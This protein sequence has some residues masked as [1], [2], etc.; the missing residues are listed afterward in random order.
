MVA[1]AEAEAIGAGDL[2]SGEVVG[3]FDVLFFLLGDVGSIDDA[4]L[5]V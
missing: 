5:F 1:E 3:P 4:G 2:L